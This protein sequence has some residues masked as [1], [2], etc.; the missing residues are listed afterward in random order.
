M[1]LLMGMNNWL[2]LRL[3]DLRLQYELIRTRIM[4]E[5]GWPVA[6]I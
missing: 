5:L 4:L 1:G 6:V 3:M 2:A